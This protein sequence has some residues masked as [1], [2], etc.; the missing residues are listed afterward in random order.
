MTLEVKLLIGKILVP[1]QTKDT[2]TTVTDIIVQSVLLIWNRDLPTEFAEIQH[3]TDNLDPLSTFPFKLS[4]LSR[5]ADNR[6][7]ISNTDFTGVFLF[8]LLNKNTLIFI[9]FWS[10][11]YFMLLKQMEVSEENIIRDFY[12]A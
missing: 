9:Y 7:N 3:I 12:S 8:I 1:N 10:R 5:S 6:T 11:N 4:I 2:E